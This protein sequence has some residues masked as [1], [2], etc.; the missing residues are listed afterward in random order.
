MN[1]NFHDC[2]AICYA[3]GPP[4]TFTTMTCN[5]NLPEIKETLTCELGQTPPDRGDVVVRVFHMK[6]HEY[7]DDIRDG[8]V[9]G[10]FRAGLPPSYTFF[11]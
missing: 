2:M 6:L 8:N 11:L 9:F 1:K 3:Y 7:L 10:P 5:P 4:D